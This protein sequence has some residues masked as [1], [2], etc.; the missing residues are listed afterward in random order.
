MKKNQQNLNRPMGL[1]QMWQHR[2]DGHPKWKEKEA[3]IF[4]VKMA[5]NFMLAEKY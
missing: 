3:K 5:E 2:Y 1:Y 4:K